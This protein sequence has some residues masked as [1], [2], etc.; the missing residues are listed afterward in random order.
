MKTASQHYILPCPIFS[1]SF[2]AFIASQ[3]KSIALVT[4]STI[5]SFWEEKLKENYP[6]W[7]FLTFPAGEAYKTRET[8]ATLEDLLIERGLG[9]DT[10]LIAFG[11]G[12]TCDLAGFV[13]ATYCRGVPFV[14]IPTSLLSMVDA[15]I[16][17][18]VGI[19]HPKGK[20][21]IGAYYDPIATVIDMDLLE[22]L[23]DMEWSN[24]FSEMIKHGIIMDEGYLKLIE[25]KADALKEKEHSVI[26]DVVMKSIDLKRSVV[27]EDR[28]ESGKRRILNFGHTLAHALEAESDYKISHGR[29]V[30]MGSLF[31]AILSCMS[32]GVTWKEVKRIEN[33]F[34]TFHGAIGLPKNLTAEQMWQ[35]LL[36]DKKAKEGKVRFVLLQ[37]LGQCFSFDGAYCS[38]VSEVLF[39]KAWDEMPKL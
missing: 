9:R 5:W 13:A 38:S 1:E 2:Q 10:L 3:K 28:N 20:N 12:V 34:T 33:I 24:G 23:P 7:N 17:S 29:A 8:K 30:A 32:G 11:G 21:L 35:W 16:G 4:D 14:N 18:K 36:R 26:Y 37:Q 25:S 6:S 15:S 31:A 27:A 19:N 39:Q 22:T